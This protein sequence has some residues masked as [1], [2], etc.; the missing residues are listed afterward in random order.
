VTRSI[1]EAISAGI[2]ALARMQAADG[3]FPLFTGAELTQWVPCGPLFSTAYIMLGAGGLLPSDNIARAVGFIRGQRRADG[4]WEYDPAIRIPPD[5][6]STACSLAALALHGDG[7]DLPG[8][9]DLLRSYWRADEGPFRTW[10]AA[11]IWSL[12][13]RDDAVVNCNVL[14]ALRLLGSSATTAEEAAVRELLNRS[15]G[16]SRYYCA[17]ATIAHAAHRAGWK[18]NGLPS[19]AMASP[20]TSDLIGCVQWLCAMPKSDA[21]LIAG[22]LCA[23]RADGSWPLWPWVT[24]AGNP[25]PFWGCP[26]I[27]TALAVEA[28]CRHPGEAIPGLQ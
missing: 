25:K 5:A 16:H 4:L 7:S 6:D 2:A 11:G 14:L 17:P 10:K 8:G 1:P 26:A 21:A 3:S 12:P 22:V 24:G 9:A 28:L 27:T 13:E 23:Q 20:K 19:S 15:N 18:Q